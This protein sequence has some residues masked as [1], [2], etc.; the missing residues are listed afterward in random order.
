MAGAGLR[1]RTRRRTGTG[2]SGALVLWASGATAVG[3]VVLVIALAVGG[4]AP[5]QA[6]AGLPDPGAFTG[7]AL[8]VIRL[9]AD[10]V[11]FIVV[12]LTLVACRVIHQQPEAPDTLSAAARLAALWSGLALFQAVLQA[13]DIAAVP[14]LTSDSGSWHRLLT[15]VMGSSQSQALLLQAALATVLAILCHGLSHSGL[16]SAPALVIALTAFAPAALTGHSAATATS[17]PSVLFGVATILLHLTA[18]SL[19][20]G[21]LAALCW[22]VLRTRTPL[23]SVIPRYSALA[24]GCV[25]GVAVSGMA[26][27]AL[28]MTPPAL[29]SDP[30]G[31]IVLLKAAALGA[32][33]CLGWLH[34]RHTLHRLTNAAGADPTHARA[35]LT[36]AAAELAMMVVTIGLAVGLAHTPTP[37]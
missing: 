32:L 15:G 17:E 21:G 8:P 7:W 6:P 19:W 37:S 2:L 31:V 11:G 36:L 20:V 23:D 35:F 14:L 28:R 9:L 1:R 10:L 18:A 12:G 27:A 4:G 24:L 26:N 22:V 29:L 3:V 30:Y 34:R 25:V 16:G 5:Q 13:S 33:T